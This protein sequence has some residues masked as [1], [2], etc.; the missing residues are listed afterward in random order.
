[1]AKGRMKT[2]AGEGLVS[3]GGGRA[4]ERYRK[5]S[6]KRSRREGPLLTFLDRP[7]GLK[8]EILLKFY[9]LTIIN[10]WESSRECSEAARGV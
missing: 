9:P 4:V 8:D 10:L 7:S 3:G 2:I 6:Q 5:E 1:V